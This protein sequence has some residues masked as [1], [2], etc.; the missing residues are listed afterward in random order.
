MRDTLLIIHIL[1][2]GAWFGTNVVQSLVTPRIASGGNQVAAHWHRTTVGL[3]RMIYMPSAIII[4][5]TGIGMLTVVDDSPYE[6][7]DAFVSMG[8]VAVII[9]SALGMGFFASRGRAAAEAYDSGDTTTA[10]GLERKIALGGLLDTF[11]IIVAVLAMVDK[12]GV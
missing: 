9:G 2:A 5:V 6:F 1:A 10:T 8:F 3:L 4:V 7:S 11:V 12:W